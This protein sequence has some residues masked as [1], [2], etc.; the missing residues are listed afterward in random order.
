MS[1]RVDLVVKAA[2]GEA[3]GEA[4]PTGSALAFEALGDGHHD[5][6]AVLADPT[7]VPGPDDGQERVGVP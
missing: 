4:L 7:R 2:G 6:P 5:L 3:G 1:Y